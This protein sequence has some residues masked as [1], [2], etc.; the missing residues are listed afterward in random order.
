ML[1]CLTKSRSPPDFYKS[2]IVTGRECERRWDGERF[3]R[4]LE[5]VVLDYR[6]CSLML[7]YI[8]SKSQ[9]N[10]SQ[11]EISWD[12]R[13]T[14]QIKWNFSL[15]ILSIM[16]SDTS[17]NNMSWSMA[18]EALWKEVHWHGAI[19]PMA[20]I[21]CLTAEVILLNIGPISEIVVAISHLDPKVSE[22]R[23]QV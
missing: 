6:K 14:N 22:N 20:D 21:S 9:L 12:F 16:F 13:Q 23:V 1:L 11:W 2:W 15:G 5:F 4:L 19:D 8:Y 7:P 3:V 18:N 17:N 10:I